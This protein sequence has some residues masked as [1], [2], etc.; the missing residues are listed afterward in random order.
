MQRDKIFLLKILEDIRDI[1]SFL[2]NIAYEKFLSETII[3]KAV[4]MSL[5]NIGE[6]VKSLS[7]DIRSRYSYVPWKKA[8]GLRDIV[9]HKYGTIDF[10]IIWQTVTVEIPSFKEDIIKLLN[11]NPPL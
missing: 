9:A 1:E 10:E 5:I 7:R 8:A 6:S 11:S 3:R 2:K 4:C